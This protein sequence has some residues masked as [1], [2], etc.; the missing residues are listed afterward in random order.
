M[1]RTIKTLVL[2]VLCAILAAGCTAPTPS[3][4]G[5]NAPAATSGGA[6]TAAPQDSSVMNATGLP[7][8]A[9]PVTY[10]LAARLSTNWA[11][12][13]NGE[14]W[15]A[16][17]AE[18]N[19][20]INW[21]TFLESESDEKFSL[22]MTSGEY[23]DGFIG[24]LGGG[25]SNIITY[26]AQGIYLPL[27]DLI[28][29]YAPNFLR[30]VAEEK[31]EI[32]NMI[33][34]PD[35]N[36]Y[37][38]PSLLYNPTIYS[39]AFINKSWLDKLGL[40]VPTTTDEFAQVL[41][42]FKNDD[43]N[44]DGKKSE[45]PL[46]FIFTDWGASEHGG[47]FGAF[48]YPLSP[49]YVIV[50][51]S[52][53]KYLG[54]QQSFKDGAAWL[55][56]LYAEGLIDQEIFTQDES[57]YTA[58]LAADPDNIGVFTS[59]DYSGSGDNKDKYVPLLPLTGPGG[60]A[61]WVTEA[62]T[63]F[64]RDQFIITTTAKNPEILV[65]WI[66]EFYRDVETSL[67]AT[68]GIGPDPAKAWDKDAAGNIV[69]NENIPDSYA[70]GQQQL[71]FAP[72]ILGSEGGKILA[73]TGVG[74]MKEEITASYAPHVEKFTSGQWHRWPIVFTTLEEKEEL[75]TLENDLVSYSKN[76][77]ARWISGEG[78][79]EEEWDKYLKELD[80]IGIAQ[81]TKLKQGIY[82]RYLSN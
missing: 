50:D 5:T 52:E 82:D 71:P 13:E 43:P 31:P 81:W 78:K 24:G 48:G 22:M 15:Q 27:N 75:A 18:T 45:I 64:Y 70:R 61:N 54:A 74:K 59:W 51:G 11:S 57:Q 55:A 35:G 76:Q 25:D 30:R 36:I 63:G 10:N 23:P 26:G 53:V 28:Q 40:S 17:Q 4:Q 46:S 62:I 9:E 80:N 66:D 56:S 38:M 32:I 72:G 79:V 2:L 14:F 16:M 69:M 58:K 33:T 20:H 1:D 19:I 77:L 68:Y 29:L 49:D 44:G 73:S 21:T 7:I 67:N 3:P 60:E 37:A 65:R 39:N 6:A 34:T 12:P 47:F 41:R 8:V 42:A